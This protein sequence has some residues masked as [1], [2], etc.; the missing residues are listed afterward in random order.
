LSES[1]SLKNQCHPDQLFTVKS[2]WWWSL[3]G[4]EFNSR[5]LL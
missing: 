5:T 1:P 2:V 4:T 3:F